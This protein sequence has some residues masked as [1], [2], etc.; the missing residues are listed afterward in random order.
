MDDFPFSFITKKPKNTKNK[1]KKKDK[2]KGKKRIILKKLIHSNS[3]SDFVIKVE[4]G[5]RKI[6][7]QLL[8]KKNIIEKPKD[9]KLKQI[10]YKK[11]NNLKKIMNKNKNDLSDYIQNNSQKV[12]LFGNPRYDRNSP[13]LFVEDFKNNL[14]EKKMGLV[15]LPSK[16]KND[17]GLYKE[18]R[19]LFDMQ[20]NI[21]MT[22]RYQYDKKNDK[23]C[24]SPRMNKN[25]KDN[26]Y[27]KM[28]QS[29]W[30]KIPKII[31]IQRI[32]RGYYIRKQVNPIVKLYRFIKNFEQFLI[33]LK[34]KDTFKR[35]KEYSA[36]RRRKVIN[37]NYITKKSNYISNRLFQNIIMIENGFR[38]Y[39][40]KIK[41]NFLLKG[42]NGRVINHISFI[43]KVI[44][45]GQ[46]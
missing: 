43:S 1:S 6:N 4:K 24:F 29:W 10:P 11:G 46:N 18:P 3:D 45:V 8:Y 19:N 42:K 36:L 12:E 40:A 7:R 31:D 5:R 33:N 26:E 25:S 9:S 35:I 30:K 16:K 13:I 22:R 14:P 2:Y 44:Y 27:F 34:L 21:S 20:R 37:G 28:V 39:K 23:K 38:C 15:P 32:F 17:I 41:K